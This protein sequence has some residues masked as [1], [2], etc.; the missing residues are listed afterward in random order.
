[1][2]APLVISGLAKGERD[3]AVFDHVLDLSSHCVLR[4]SQPCSC[5]A[6]AD[7]SIMIKFAKDTYLSEKTELRSKLQAPAK[8]PAG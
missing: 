7:I 6:G 2:P 5:S 3:I 1:M 4:S 8:I